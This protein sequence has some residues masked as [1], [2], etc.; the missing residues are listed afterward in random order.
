[1]G[2]QI[3]TPITINGLTLKNRIAYPS[4]G[5][6]Y[7]LDRSVNDRY[8]HYYMEK[9]RGGS[10][11]V[12][13][14][15]VAVDNAGGMGVTLSL[16]TDDHLD[17]FAR[18]ARGIKS[19]GA[20]PWVQLFHA[21]GYA[22]SWLIGEQPMAPS[23]VYNDYA[24]EVPREMTIDDIELTIENFIRAGERAKQCGF[25]GVEIIGSAGYLITQFLSPIRNIRADRYGGS[26][27]NRTRFPAELIAGMRARLGKNYP[28]A[29]RMAGNDFING[30]NTD[31]EAP[32]IARVYERSGVDMIN[33]T[34]GWHEARIPQLPMRVPRTAYAYLALN[35][36]R[37][38]SVPVMASNRI[39]TPAE[40]E[41]IVRDGWADMVNLGRVLLADPFWPRKAMEGRDAEIRPCVACNQGCT[42]TIFSGQPV[43]CIVNPRTGF[44]GERTIEKARRP[45]VVMVAGAGPA[46]LEAAVRA[47]E[48]G[49]EVHLY[50]K[51]GDIGG[52][53]RIAC[54]PPHKEEL[55]EI[56]RFYRAMIARRGINLHLNTILTV[57]M[58]SSGGPDY[59]I[60]AE[61]A[62]PVIPACAA[63][64][65]GVL[66]S[67]DVLAGDPATGDEVAVIG[68]GSV[69][70]ETA[71]FVAS[72]GT[73]SPEILHF[74]FVYGGE[75]EERLRDLATRGTKKV[76]VFEMGPKPAAD[77]GRSTRWVLMKEA[78]RYGV[79]VLTDAKVVSVMDGVVEFE[80]DGR[81][82]SRRFDTVI[83]SAGARSERRL[84]DEMEK[85]GIPFRVVGD[86]VAPG[87]IDGA[88]H[89]AFLA[90]MEL[91]KERVA[92]AVGR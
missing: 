85:T 78:A 27:E 79:E 39:T 7:S 57:D 63:G 35:I 21:G 47:A 15:P 13:V 2:M 32:D 6:L 31:V 67:W 81:Q 91:E 36:K 61:G 28:V 11:L 88:I 54:A 42:D 73:I 55:S 17:S 49:H 18:A 69:G 25:D 44:E 9:A 24:K 51:S 90:V 56:V 43:F 70:V 20:S 46:G 14:G 71:L 16:A 62:R 22:A 77:M 3:F 29:I 41:R 60:V 65:R 68:G 40:A 5:L 66:S 38:V 89:G 87:K 4:M 64:D 30:S 48:A 12:T 83:V 92:E 53:L 82:S 1:M 8:Y 10:A 84:A 37:A 80:R 26:F 45:G 33:V 86:C 72:K 58:V 52:Q 59:V 75:K 74:L 76:T 23:A 34:G 19:E 50:E